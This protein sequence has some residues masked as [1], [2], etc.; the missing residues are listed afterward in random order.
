VKGSK[1]M[2]D[3]R[4]TRHARERVAHRS[5]RGAD[6]LLLLE[7]GDHTTEKRR[8]AIALQLSSDAI[9]EAT[10]RGVPHAALERASRLIAIQGPDGDVLTAYRGERRARGGHAHRNRFAATWRR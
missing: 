6:L 4:L 9:R 2:N 8:G 7:E 3:F 1:I 10:R 5:I